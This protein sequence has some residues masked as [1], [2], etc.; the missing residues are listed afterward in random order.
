MKENPDAGGIIVTGDISTAGLLV[1]HLKEFAEGFTKPIYFVLGNHDY[2]GS[3]FSKIDSD[4]LKALESFSKQSIKNLHWLN[5]GSHTFDEHIIVGVGGW[6]DAYNG[7]PNTNVQINDFYEIEELMPGIQYREVLLDLVRKRAGRQAD[8]LALML[9]EACAKP[10]ELIIVA[11]HVA[12][13]EEAAWHM[14]K[15]SDRDWQ[16]WFS[17]ASTGA[18]L[19][20]YADRHPDKKFIVLAGHSHGSGIYQRRDNMIVYTGRAQYGFPDLCGTI[21]TKERKLW[22]YD[23]LGKKV[24]RSY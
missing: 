6:Y 9:K 18:V 4:V 19:D 1:K 13:Y 2:Y 8:S 12:P 16:P 20:T 17:S 14:G 21:Y 7:N 22:A 11:T 23:P 24:E 10:N 3:S 5:E 15:P